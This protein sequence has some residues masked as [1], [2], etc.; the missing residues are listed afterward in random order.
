MDWLQQDLTVFDEA[1]R[2]ELLWLESSSIERSIQLAEQ[3]LQKMLREWRRSQHLTA[4]RESLKDPTE[5]MVV[6]PEE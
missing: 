2:P 6:L 1:M 4:K 3:Q 5:K